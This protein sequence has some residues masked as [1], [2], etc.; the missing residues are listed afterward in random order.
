ME[1]PEVRFV[2]RRKETRVSSAEGTR[3][4]PG[5]SWTKEDR[6]LRQLAIKDF[7]SSALET[8]L[9]PPT[10]LPL[11]S[12]ESPL[13]SSLIKHGTRGRS[14]GRKTVSFS[15]LS[16]KKVSNVN[17][18]LQIMQNGTDMIKLRAN[19][20]QFRRHFSLDADLSYIRWTP[21]NKKPHKAR[22]LIETVRE[23]RVGR[24]TEVLRATE[25]C[26]VDMQEECAFSIIYG[27]EYECL[28]LVASTA[29]DANIWVTGLMAL[30]SG[31][32][33]SV[34]CAPSGSMATLRERW[35][36]SLFEDAD[37]DG[38]G[39][40]AEKA[41]VRLIL[42]TNGRLLLSR[43]RQKVKEA[44]AQNA[45]DVSRG[46]VSKTQFVEIFKDIATR[47]E[48]YF[49]MV[50]YANKDYLTTTDLQ[51][52]L[53]TEQGM[54]GV[55][56]D[57][58][59]RLIEQF[60][61]APEAKENNFMTVDGFTNYLLC[62]ECAL[63]DPGRQSV[64]QEMDLPF[65]HYFISAS[66]NTYLVEDQ[67]KGPSSA[68]GYVSALRRN[69]RFL[70]LDLWDPAEDDAEAEPVVFHGGTLTS[71]MSVSAALDVIAELAFERTRYP[72]FVRLEVHLSE[73]YQKKLVELIYSKLGPRV[74]RPS[75]DPVDWTDPQNMPTPR[76]FQ[77][78]IIFVGKR[79][80]EGE[81]DDGE[82][83]EEDESYD[84]HTGRVRKERRIRLLRSLSDLIAPF[85]EARTLRD[86]GP[87]ASGT[88]SPQR[89]LVSMT[90]SNCLRM[91]HSSP[92]EFARLSQSL[93]TRVTPNFVRVDSSNLNPQEFWNFGVNLV[94]LNYQTPGLMMDLQEGKFADNGGCGYVL[95][96]TIM[97]E[98][99]FTLGDKLPFAPQILHLRILSAQQLPR[100]RGSSAKGDSAD[101]FVVVEVFGIPTDCAE[102][103]TKTVRNDSVNPCFDESFQFQVQVPE[104]AIVRF[105]VLDDD[106]IGDDFI[107]QYSIPFE[108]LQSGYRHITLHNNEGDPLE[109]CS[110]FCH[111]AVTNRRGGGKAKKRGMSVKR[112]TQRV[113]TGMKTIGVKAVD[114]QFKMAV[115]PL[116]DSIAMRNQ[117]EAAL[118]EW[119]E[120]CGLG[121]TGTI[122]QG[123]RLVHSRIVTAALNASPPPSPHPDAVSN[124]IVR[125]EEGSPRFTILKDERDYPYVET[126]G[127]IPEAMQKT[128][129]S[130]N[131]VLSKCTCIL[132]KTDVLLV[133]LEEATKRI[134]DSYGEMEQ[135]CAEAGLRGQKATRA[136]ENFAWNVRLLKAQLTLM[137]KAQDE[138]S[139]IFVQVL[140]AGAL[141]GVVDP[142]SRKSSTQT[143]RKDSSHSGSP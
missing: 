140:D 104:L 31:Q 34:E 12:P 98:D 14:P 134:C 130:L 85:A 27:D 30:T 41:A 118:S 141:L 18:C 8:S 29:D 79:L 11:A 91:V 4:S 107:G 44:V 116:A 25:N 64:C 73:E 82:V 24:N 42:A 20:R 1:S 102:E 122:R 127:N 90:E 7:F 115:G 23:I 13:R 78:K 87:F 57:F 40:L 133:Q 114:E 3:T 139:N 50:R 136:V 106:Y 53:E 61:P 15:S 60:E 99:L 49:L 123:L 135:L 142:S 71:K 95:K 19:V 67:L 113:Q 75:E 100:P 36:E 121:P 108:C 59:E 28:D 47:P 76:K 17:D 54:T 74:Y 120:Q 105:L 81:D 137:S 86:L 88:L 97:R 129:S 93:L 117:L 52:F 16:D 101:P 46:R 131:N 22:I 72:L 103:R 35:L 126:Y 21:T 9:R 70:E 138:A 6:T 110:L 77:M 2:G 39:L 5:G 66:H 62:G 96:P 83:T 38:E 45:E 69:C 43:V 32:K 56:V 10:S 51:L 119:Q 63:F 125:S 55:T 48:V 80:A 112:K 33:L 124:G 84:V 111:V 128:F 37:V 94:A 143:S 89:H 92:P 26:L 65:S 58:C 132:T 68:D 109:N